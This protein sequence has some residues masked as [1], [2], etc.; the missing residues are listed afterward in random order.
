VALH[1][2]GARLWEI[3]PFYETE[4]NKSLA[5]VGSL[6]DSVYVSFYKA[7]RGV[8]G[9]MVVHTDKIFI[10]ELRIWQRRAGGNAF[11]MAYE[12]IDCERGFNEMIGTFSKKRDKMVSIVGRISAAT[13][14]FLN[15]NMQPMVVFKPETPTCFQVL[16]YFH[17]YTED[18]LL[19][20]RDLVQLRTNVR[21]FERIRPNQTLDDISATIR[22]APTQDESK[23]RLSQGCKDESSHRVHFI[24]WRIGPEIEQISDL[25]FVDAYVH[26]CTALYSIDQERVN[27]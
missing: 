7:L 22:A 15:A 10:Q 23:T 9:A 13:K 6:F 16:T 21:I 18:E 26:F 14:S 20:A 27:R 5:D 8:T 3:E 25:V 12:V 24:E 11:T 2:D 19:V 1:C 4:S 17:G